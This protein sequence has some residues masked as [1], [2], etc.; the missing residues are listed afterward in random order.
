MIN[1]CERSL[2]RERKFHFDKFM[3]ILLGC[4]FWSII[5]D[6]PPIQTPPKIVRRRSL[7]PVDDHAISLNRLILWRKVLLNHIVERRLR[8]RRMGSI[9]IYDK[10]LAIAADEKVTSLI[11]LVAASPLLSLRADDSLL[12][13][14]VGAIVCRL[15][16][17]ATLTIAC[18]LFELYPNPKF[19]LPARLYWTTACQSF[20]PTR[21]NRNFPEY[22]RASAA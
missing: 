13:E 8:Q 19:L 16:T 17:I 3:Q 10:N 15:V 1:W 6:F 12:P 9:Q 5:V 11:H 20:R 14:T 7:T 21:I 2:V 4:E 22:W 18:V